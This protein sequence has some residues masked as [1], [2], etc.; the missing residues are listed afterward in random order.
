[1]TLKNYYIAT[2]GSI[3][4]V[5]LLGFAA[6]AFANPSVFTST[7]QTAAATS[8]VVYMTPGTATTTLVYDSRGLNGTLQ[9]KDGNTYKTDGAVLF[10]QL[11]ASSTATILVTKLEYSNGNNCASAPTGC[12]WYENNIN[13]YAAGAI[14]IATANSFTYTF[15]STTPGGTGTTSDFG[16]KLMNIDTPARYVRVVLT[17][18]GA[19]G[20]VWAQILPRKQVVFQ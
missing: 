6:I 2:A 15:A 1:M 8:T 18:T 16:R 17:L 19:N 11:N 4:A 5:V 14:A 10:T 12:D 13:V 9:A 7:A 20:S 3:V